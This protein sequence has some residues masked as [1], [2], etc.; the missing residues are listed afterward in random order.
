MGRGEA[1]EKQRLTF[2]ANRL[3]LQTAEDLER[4]LTSKPMTDD[5][6]NRRRKDVTAAVHRLR[7][8]A[9]RG[10]T[11]QDSSRIDDP[12]RLGHDAA[13]P[14]DDRGL[15]APAGEGGAE[16]RIGLE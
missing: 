15:A 3:D 11:D 4:Y 5:E 14:E 9:Q 2:A 6:R 12:P 13:G 8:G 1:F 7:P 16:T 10:E